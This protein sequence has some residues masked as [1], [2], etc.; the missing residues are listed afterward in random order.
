MTRVLGCLAVL[1][2][3]YVWMVTFFALP[4]IVVFAISLSDAVVGIPPYAPLVDWS[5]ARFLGDVENYTFLLGDAYYLDGFLG[6]I[7]IAAV[8]TFICF[9]IGYPMALAISRVRPTRRLPLLLLL[10]LP[11]WTSFLI[12]TYAW[13]TLLNSNGIINN[14]LLNLGLRETP[15]LMLYTDFSVYLGIVYAYL[16]FMVLPIYAVIERHDLGLLEAAADLGAKP[17]R[18]FLSV[19]LPLSIP[20]IAAGC[21][22]V[23]VPALGEFVVPELLGGSDFLMIGRLLWTETFQNRDWPLAATVTIVLLVLVVATVVSV[24]RIVD[25][26]E[27]PL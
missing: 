2:P 19:T 8:A 20:G 26:R 25:M 13:I 17:F 5:S 27:R 11:F 16:P 12:R 9:L 18:S 22:L 24:Q 21:L 3:P 7:R 6:S 15:I 14:A 23:F 1:M 10:M 4:I